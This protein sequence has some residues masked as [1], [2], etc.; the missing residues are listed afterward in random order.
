MN[1]NTF[2]GLAFAGIALAGV[3]FANTAHAD[4][5]GWITTKTK[6]DLLTTDGVSGTAINVD[7]TDGNVVLHGKVKSDIEKSKAE[8]VAKSIE[9]VKSVKN[10][11]QVVPTSSEKMVDKKDSDLK[12]AAEKSLKAEKETGDIAIASVNNGVVLL[13]GKADTIEEH[14]RAVRAVARTPGVKRVASEVTTPDDKLIAATSTTASASPVVATKDNTK[15][16]MRHEGHKMGEGTSDRKITADAKIRLMADSKV[17]AL[18]INVDT[19]D[20]VV[21]LFGAVPSAEAKMAAQAD[22]RK[23]AGVKGV[24]DELQIVP[25]GDKKVI[26]AKDDDIEKSVKGAF[27]NMKDFEK[28][29]VNAKNGVVRLSGEVPHTAD[30]LK[31]A[32]IARSQ[33]GVRAVE[34]DLK[35]AEK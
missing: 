29:S 30:E 5:D 6:L 8:S 10:L 11:L 15:E 22:V 9:G 12:T 31:A 24:K 4:S 14:L 13:S 27:T 2:R 1:M 21:T 7:T 19:D 16:K 20:G 25:A 35:V 18:D 32:T 33:P 23:I 26:A 17:P 28:I 3:S 34:E